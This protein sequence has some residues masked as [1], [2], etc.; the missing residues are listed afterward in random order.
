MYARSKPTSNDLLHLSLEIFNL[1]L[2]MLQPVIQ[3]LVIMPLI[4]MITDGL[5]NLKRVLPMVSAIHLTAA[6]LSEGKVASILFAS[7]ETL[8]SQCGRKFIEEVANI[9]AVFV[10]EFH[11][12][13]S[14]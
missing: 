4:A 3:I 1:I 7:P 2:F 12:V 5:A 14:W 9:K 8:L 11:I 10:D 6:T 13:S